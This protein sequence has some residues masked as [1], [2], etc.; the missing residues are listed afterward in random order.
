MILYVAL[1]RGEAI[2][3]P[4]ATRGDQ[5]WLGAT[6]RRVGRIPGA[7]GRR[8]RLHILGTSHWRITRAISVSEHCDAGTA[9]G[10]VLTGKIHVR[11]KGTAVLVGAGQDVVHVG[12]VAPHFD[13][14]AL[15]VESIGLFDLVVVAVEI[16]D[17]RCDNNTFGILPWTIPDTVT[18]I[19]RVRAAASICAEVST[20]GSC[21]PRQQSVPATG[22]AHLHRPIHRDLR[23][24]L[25]RRWL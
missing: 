3:E 4:V 7:R 6:A 22:N 2:E 1:L 16:G 19:N 17:A 23:P 21:C 13:W 15:F 25:D 10:P 11:G 5:I 24:C 8:I 18:R 9:A 20:P 14:L 12:R